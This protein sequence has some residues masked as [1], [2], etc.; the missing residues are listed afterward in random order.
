MEIKNIHK[1]KNKW[2]TL[3]LGVKTLRLLYKI[4]LADVLIPK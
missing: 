1:D 3:H 4:L 2:Y